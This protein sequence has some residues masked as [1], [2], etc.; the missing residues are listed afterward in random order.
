MCG[1]KKNP[2]NIDGNS[3]RGKGRR[4]NTRSRRR[5]GLF[6]HHHHLNNQHGSNNKAI[7]FVD[8]EL[9]SSHSDVNEGDTNTHA[10]SFYTNI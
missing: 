4:R 2:K 1:G 9:F 10:A 6:C 5:F 7:D 3:K 8:K